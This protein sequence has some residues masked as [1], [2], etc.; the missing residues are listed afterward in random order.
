MTIPARSK[1]IT[2]IAI[3]FFFALK[4]IPLAP[5]TL[6]NSWYA[7]LTMIVDTINEM[8]KITIINTSIPS[9]LI[10]NIV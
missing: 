1:A 6:I 3:I 9:L 4:N 8:T 10:K 7:T 2:R 5:I